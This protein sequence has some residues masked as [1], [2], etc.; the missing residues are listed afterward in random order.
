MTP[1][2]LRTATHAVARPNYQRS[3]LTAGIVHI[4]VGGFHRSHQAMVIDRLLGLGGARDWAICGVGLLPVDRVMADVL[5]SQD[6]LYTLV[7]KHADGRREARVIGSI[8]DYLYCP[9]DPEA[10]LERLASPTTKIVS[11]TVTEGGYNISPLTGE[12]DLTSPGVVADL[13]P[14][15]MPQTVFGLVTEGL[16]RRRDLGLPAFTVMSCDNIQS[17]GEMARRAF[18]TYATALDPELATWIS[19]KARFPNSMVDRITPVTTSQDRLEIRRQFGVNDGWPVVCEPFFQ[20]VLEDDFADGRPAY[21]KGGVQLVDDVVPYELMKLRLLNVSHQGIA[22]FGHLSGYRYAH[23]AAADPVFKRFLLAY[24]RTEGVPTLRPVPGIDLENY[25]ASLIERFA[26]PEVKDTIARLA[27]ESSDRI[28]KWL[29][30]VIME[31]LAAGRPVRLS[32]AIVASWARYAEGVDEAGQPIT[33]VDRLAGTLTATAQT[34]LRDPTAFL[35]NRDLFGDLVD[36]DRFVDA[37]LE[38]LDSLHRNGAHAT[39]A[40]LAGELAPR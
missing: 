36:D 35:K 28:P 27:A 34:Q 5:H 18:L 17:N 11:L 12:F 4:G 13:V 19:R 7:E 16:R 33:V 38:A 32:A 23:E 22:Y 31:N 37:Y 40:K 39:V 21:D 29:V 6:C 10:V 24:M 14:G 2:M 9:D 20:W 15:A 3:D 25:T 1:G 8:I 26:N 30:P